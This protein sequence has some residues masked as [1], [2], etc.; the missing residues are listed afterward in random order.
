MRN[1]LILLLLS[2][3]SPC[4]MAHWIEVGHSDQAKVYVDRS[5]IKREGKLVRMTDLYDYHDTQ[6]INELK[7]R[8]SRN[9]HEY[10]CS[11][12]SRRL[13]GF[14]WFSQNMGKGEVVLRDASRRDWDPNAPV[15][16]GEKLLEVACDQ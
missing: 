11:N 8:S 1:F 7:F 12:R 4:A 13:L 16:F 3:A 9:R 2:A 5:T 15:H 10:N 14:K 6:E